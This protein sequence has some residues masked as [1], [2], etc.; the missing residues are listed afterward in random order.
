MVQWLDTYNRRCWHLVSTPL[1][2][3]RGCFCHVQ[4]KQDLRA[5]LN[6]SGPQLIWANPKRVKTQTAFPH[7]LLFKFEEKNNTQSVAG[8]DKTLGI[9]AKAAETLTQAET[10]ATKHTH[11]RVFTENK[12]TKGRDKHNRSTSR[13]QGPRG[14]TEVLLGQRLLHNEQ[15]GQ[16]RR[17]WDM[18]K[19]CLRAT[20]GT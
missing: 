18:N 13:I 9:L 5:G 3:Q 19:S 11:T 1:V 4:H 8:E 14:T 15:R 12:V 7:S 6:T 20:Q 2:P 16:E 17:R 10:S